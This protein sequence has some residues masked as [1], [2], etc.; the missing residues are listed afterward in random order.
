MC[1][2]LPRVLGVA[3]LTDGTGL[4]NVLAAQLDNTWWWDGIVVLIEFGV[5]GSWN[6]A[7]S[8]MA[9]AFVVAG[10]ERSGILPLVTS[11]M[12]ISMRISM[13][14]RGSMA[15]Y[16]HASRPAMRDMVRTPASAS[17]PHIHLRSSTSPF[18][19]HK[20]PLS[21]CSKREVYASRLL[22]FMVQLNPVLALRLP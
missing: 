22:L 1:R 6:I 15:N 2:F 18:M 16:A 20:D 12:S 8:E 3:P 9:F 11:S 10:M 4:D 13:I 14:V 21:V 5:T 7:A 17:S 19:G